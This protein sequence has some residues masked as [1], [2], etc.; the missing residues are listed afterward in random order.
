MRLILH[1]VPRYEKV[2]SA[3]RERNLVLAGD[4]AR[5]AL[6]ASGLGDVAMA[7][8]PCWLW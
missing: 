7:L 4:L 3:E 6:G 1:K 2:A 8:P 5:E